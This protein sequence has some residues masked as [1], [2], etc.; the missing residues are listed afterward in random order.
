MFLGGEPLSQPEKVEQWVQI[1]AK[2]GGISTIVT[3]GTFGLPELGQWP[4]T[5]THFFVS[6]D[7]DK[8]AMDKVRGKDVFEKVKTVAAGRK[9]VMLT[10]IIFCN[11]PFIFVVISL[12][13]KIKRILSDR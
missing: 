6:C 7:G 4:R 11:T 2:L 12:K 9:D 10:V 8:P 13:H 3:N 5:H 1:V